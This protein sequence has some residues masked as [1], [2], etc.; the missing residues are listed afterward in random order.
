M[1]YRRLGKQKTMALGRW[2]DV[3]LDD[4]RER[5][6]AALKT[7]AAGQNPLEEKMARIQTVL[8]GGHT[9]GGRRRMDVEEREGGHGADHAGQ[10]ALLAWPPANRRHHHT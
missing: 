6:D 3:D 5:R 2:P 7:T 1:N 9:F 8:G 4:A 10:A